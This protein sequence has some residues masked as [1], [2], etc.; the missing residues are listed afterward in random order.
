VAEAAKQITDLSP[1][2]L[3]ETER[4]EAELDQF[5]EKRARAAKDRKNAEDLW[6]RSVC[7]DRK[8]R[9]NKAAEDWYEYHDNM[10]QSHKATLGSLVNYHQKERARY[11]KILGISVPL[12]EAGAQ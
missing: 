2:E 3:A 10:I 5:V 9:R 4:A 11:A 7:E 8:K 6:D 12:E 1:E